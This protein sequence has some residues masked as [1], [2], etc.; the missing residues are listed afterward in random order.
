MTRSSFLS[1][2]RLRF[3]VE[4]FLVELLVIL[5]LDADWVIRV[6]FSVDLLDFKVWLP[7]FF[8]V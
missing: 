5:G 4:V 3:T 8:I 2:D 1:F 7:P 6:I